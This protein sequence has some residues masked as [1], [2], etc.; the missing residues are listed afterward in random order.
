MVYD[1]FYA[2]IS[3]ISLLKVVRAEGKNKKQN[4]TTGSTREITLKL[5]GFPHRQKVL[6]IDIQLLITKRGCV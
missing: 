6:D 3:E 2:K 5:T 4:P 1:I